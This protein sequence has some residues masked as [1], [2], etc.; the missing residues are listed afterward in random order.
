MYTYLRRNPGIE[1][2][3]LSWRLFT[4]IPQTAAHSALPEFQSNIPPPYAQ[5]YEPTWV[6]EYKQQQPDRSRRGATKRNSAKE[7]GPGFL[8][9]SIRRQSVTSYASES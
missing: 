3:F 4:Q 7:F 9:T 1:E 5:A 6:G 8:Q 2:M